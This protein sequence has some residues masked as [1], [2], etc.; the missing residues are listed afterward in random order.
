MVERKL[1]IWFRIHPICDPHTKRQ[2]V[3]DVVILM[4]GASSSHGHLERPRFHVHRM[5]IYSMRRFV[6]GVSIMDT[7][8]APFKHSQD[9]YDKETHG[10]V[11]RHRVIFPKVLS[12]QS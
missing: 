1:L 10:A 6:R 2:S 3:G 4:C 9:E 11:F 5:A 8:Q 12:M 7:L